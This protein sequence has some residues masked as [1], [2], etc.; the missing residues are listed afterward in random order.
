MRRVIVIEYSGGE[1]T[2]FESITEKMDG[3]SLFKHIDEGVKKYIE[4][5]NVYIYQVKVTVKFLY[6]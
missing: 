2:E 5:Y 1:R 6:L 3:N 4:R